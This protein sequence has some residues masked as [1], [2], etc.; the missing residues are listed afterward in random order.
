M[1]G[2]LSSGCAVELSSSEICATEVCSPEVWHIENLNVQEPCSPCM[3][4]TE[5]QKRASAM[6]EMRKNSNTKT[7]SSIVISSVE[8]PHTKAPPDVQHQ[9]V[10]RRSVVKNVAMSL[11]GFKQQ[12]SDDYFGPA[13]IKISQRPADEELLFGSMRGEINKVRKALSSGAA[14]TL[15]NVRGL[16]PLHLAA[17]SSGPD[18]IEAAQT[19]ITSRAEIHLRDQNGWTCLHHA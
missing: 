13:T 4:P 7:I 5:L 10:Q 3:A 19:L 6:Q 11:L 1:G 8:E 18:S 17:G 14:V 12:T 15:T 16:T 2:T 9:P